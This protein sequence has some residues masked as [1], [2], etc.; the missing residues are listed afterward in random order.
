MADNMKNMTID[1]IL[2]SDDNITEFS[3][4]KFLGHELM[5]HRPSN[6]V[7]ATHLLIKCKNDDVIKKLSDWM[8]LKSSIEF[9]KYIDNHEMEAWVVMASDLKM[10]DN[11]LLTNV[12]TS[13]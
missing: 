10:K 9:I 8:K 4:A 13:F 3:K 6:T 11:C 2:D 1:D 5:V 7:N 12:M